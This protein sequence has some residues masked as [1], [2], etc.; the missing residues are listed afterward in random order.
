VASKNT[1]S[2]T[3]SEREAKTE[4]SGEEIPAAFNFKLDHLYAENSG[5]FGP[6]FGYYKLFD[7][8]RQQ[9]GFLVFMGERESATTAESRRI[10]LAI[11]GYL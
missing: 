10:T 8:N 9:I 5:F 2:L 3:I 7:F 11:F 1:N 6:T 4:I